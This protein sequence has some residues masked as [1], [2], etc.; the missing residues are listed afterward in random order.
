MGIK[1]IALINS[2]RVE[3]SFWRSP[4]LAP[5]SI[6][7]QLILGL[8]QGVD[9]YLP[10]VTLHPLFKPFVEDELTVWSEGTRRIVCHPDTP[11][12]CPNQLSEPVTLA[13]GPEGG[14]IPYEV[15]KLES[16]GFQAVN[17]GPRILRVETAIPFVLGRLFS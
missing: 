2:Y 16:V 4:A 7:E 12:P 13:I 14:F 8:E 10:R 17:L 6:R 5:D 11:I 9:T 1:E 3:K 15:D